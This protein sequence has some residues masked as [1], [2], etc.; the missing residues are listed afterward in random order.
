MFPKSFCAS[1]TQFCLPS[2]SLGGEWGGYRKWLRFYLD[3][4]HKYGHSYA[5]AESLP[6]FLDKLASKGQSDALRSQAAAAVELYYQ[7]LAQSAGDRAGTERAERVEIREDSPPYRVG[8]E[9]KSDSGKSCGAGRSG[10]AEAAYSERNVAEAKAPRPP[11]DSG[12]GASW[13]AEFSALENEISVRHYS[14]KTLSTYRLW[15]R[16]FQAFLKSK[17]PGE[18]STDDVK[19]FLT[20]LAVNQGGGGIDSEPGV[21]RRRRTMCHSQA[22]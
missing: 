7:M 20:D 2:V 15:V 14:R 4:C 9:G 11:A 17:P 1:S 3:F 13:Q 12:Q 21:A 5:G 10:G 22:G 6:P 19:A 8:T 18:L 16:K